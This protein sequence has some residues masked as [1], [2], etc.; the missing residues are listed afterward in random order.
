MPGGQL[1]AIAFDI[2]GGAEI[3]RIAAWQSDFQ[4][5]AEY[6]RNRRIDSL[7]QTCI[8]ACHKV[9]GERG[10]AMPKMRSQE[11]L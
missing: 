3:T 9:V 7:Q 6:G 10:I 5:I 1:R 8:T 2:S 4:R 11:A